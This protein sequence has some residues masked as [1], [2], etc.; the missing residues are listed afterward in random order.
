MPSIRL[1]HLA[2][3]TVI[4]LPASA[5][6]AQAARTMR[7]NAIHS[8]LVESGPGR[9]HW[10]QAQRLLGLWAR[11][12]PFTTRLDQVE[13]TEARL[14]DPDDTL[15][16]ALDLLRETGV[17]LALAERDGRLL[18]ILGT[19][20]LVHHLI[21]TR[22][23]DQGQTLGGLV[24]SDQALVLDGIQ[25][26]RGLIQSLETRGVSVALQLEQGCPVGLLTLDDLI[27][28]I[29]EGVDP[30]DRRWQDQ[31]RP[32]PV[33]QAETRITDAVQHC[34]HEQIR[35]LVVVDGQGG[36]L[37]VVHTAGLVDV[38][39]R[40]WLASIEAGY[41]RQPPTLAPPSEQD[42]KFRKLFEIYPDA[43]LVIDA[44]DG[45][46]LEFNQ[47]AYRQLGYTREEFARLKI[48]DYEAKESPE[49]VAVHV[50][51]ILTQGWDDFETQ[52]RCKDGRIIDV[53][54]KV[55]RLDLDD[56]QLMVAVFR[57]ITERNQRDR[58]RRW[59]EERLRLATEAARL[60]IWDYDPKQDHLIWDER[61]FEIYGVDPTD[62]GGCFADW[63]T[64]V[65]PK[66]LPEVKRAFADLIDA[67]HPFAVEFPIRRRCDG[68]R[69]ILR[70]L[71]QVTRDAQGR[72]LRVVGVNEDITESYELQRA[73]L[74]REQRLQQLAEQSRTVTWEVDAQ[75]LYTEVSPVA[76][77]VWGYAPDELV[78]RCHFYD[79]HP[80]AGRE[81][82]KDE[83]LQGFAQQL[84]FQGYVNPI[85]RK[86]GQVIWVSTNAIPITDDQGRLVGYRGSDIDITEAK[87]AKD[88][89]EAE[90]ERFR[91]I[92]EKTASGVAVFRPV[93]GGE[94]FVF[95]DYNPAGERMDR[96]PRETVIGRRVT[97]CFPAI[98]EMGLLDVFKRV[99][100]TG[101]TEVL[102]CALYQ[103]EHLQVWRENTVFKLSSGE[104]VS[105][106]NDLTE[107]KQ[108]Q[109]A[110][111][112][113]NQAKS[114][115]LA[116]MSHEIRTPMNAVIGLSELLLDTPLTDK[117]RDYLVKIRDSSRLLLAIIND[118]LDYSKIE[119][120]KLELCIQPFCLEDLLDQLRTI[121]G[122]QA[123]TKNIELLFDLDVGE[124]TWVAGDALRLGQVLINLLSNAVKFTERG[125]V[126]L[127]IRQLGDTL[128]GA[129]RL[130]FSVCDTGIGI[131]P[132]QRARLFQPFSQADSSTTRRYGGTGLGLTISRCLLEKMGATLDLEST[133]GVGSRFY[134]DLTLPLVDGPADC[135]HARPNPAAFALGGRV[136]VVDDQASARDILRRL[137]ET[138]GFEVE[139]ADSGLAALQAVQEA[140]HSGRPFRFI[141]NGLE[142]ARRSRWAPDAQGD[143]Q[144]ASSRPPPR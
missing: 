123:E 114:E 135:A 121:F 30:G 8:V 91:G 141:L 4:S 143:A 97:E 86:D 104:I 85:Q 125:Q 112:R 60:G 119:A 130:R 95:L 96:T 75:G 131:T 87:Y 40:A 25:D 140:E 23:I 28:L 19:Q 139:E 29:D 66:A 138:H 88:A 133:P 118:I 13:L 62:F 11:G 107:I 47:Q 17:P 116:N 33:F 81:T 74:D 84:S 71:A 72:A 64:L 92:F 51:R 110:A 70:G 18:G 129:V 113:A 49:D 7:L 52:H 54:V 3:T 98:F 46:T 105:V 9:Y 136:L 128:D 45:S 20:E 53:N 89:L 15:M 73:L 115:F 100:R 137:L 99:N 126:V 5:T 94:D 59:I 108:A 56:R 127:T 77:R 57:D 1:R 38:Y 78:G 32:P 58:Q 43:T 65:D 10:V 36:F 22:L 76:E 26:L 31:L 44:S 61:M 27:R 90:K 48:R 80:E 2:T 117:Q 67:D 12:V 35:H 21:H 124:I 106:Y 93:D 111:E 6:L 79:L 144:F 42:S 69:R 16:R 101:Q 134:F 34:Q 68:A 24:Y 132:E 142:N 122:N 82:F 109:Q 83:V 50:H 37:G 55:A 14:L 120:G 102:P 41:N 63:E 103:D 39:Y